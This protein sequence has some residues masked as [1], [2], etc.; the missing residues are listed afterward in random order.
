MSGENSPESE[1]IQ[2]PESRQFSIKPRRFNCIR[3]LRGAGCCCCSCCCCSR[4]RRLGIIS[5]N[6]KGRRV[7]PG[8]QP[9]SLPA[10]TNGFSISWLRGLLVGFC[11]CLIDYDVFQLSNGNIRWHRY[12]REVWKKAWMYKVLNSSNTDVKTRK[13]CKGICKINNLAIGT[14]P[15]RQ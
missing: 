3:W 8:D 9:R 4:R 7:I 5:R 12:L 10:A 15:Q 14:G 11:I 13:F 1:R 6:V 2:N